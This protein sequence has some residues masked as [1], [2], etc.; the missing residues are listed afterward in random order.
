[1]PKHVGNLL[2]SDVYVYWCMETWNI[3]LI[4]IW[5]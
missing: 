1:M 3:S 5:M 2:T 4:K